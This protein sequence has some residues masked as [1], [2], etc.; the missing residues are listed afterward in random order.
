MV[1]VVVVLLLLLLRL[2]SPDD[3][4]DVVAMPSWLST[5]CCM[6]AASFACF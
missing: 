6:A 2:V 1:V 5:T 4:V 3:G